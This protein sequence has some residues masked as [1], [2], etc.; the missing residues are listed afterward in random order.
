MKYQA[1]L[2]DFDYTLGD[3][4]EPIVHSYTAALT[5]MG[6]PAPEREHVRETVGHTLQ[7]GYTMLTG[8]SSEEK[9]QDFF[10]RF[11]RHAG[12]I[13]VR[14]TVLCPGAERVL[15]WLGQQ[16][17]RTGIVSTKGADQLEGIFG[18][19]NLRDKLALIIGGQDVTK[20]KPDP[21]GLNVALSRLGLGKDQ[22][23]FCGD[24]VIDAKTAMA[25]GVEF[26]AVLNGTT[27]EN[28]F[29]EY[30]HVYIAPDLADLLAWMK[31]ME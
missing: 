20:A 14:D 10:L 6:W 9:R 4:T 3:S 11:K 12:P 24:T 7:D 1:V 30:P 21:E 2:F 19:L 15:N 8:D 22:V 23:L 26:C 18:K 29:K 16:K 13:M 5:E 17:I 27:P 25:A 28:A 31:E